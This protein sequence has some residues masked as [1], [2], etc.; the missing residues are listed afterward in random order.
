VAAKLNNK[1][2]NNYSSKCSPLSKEKET[3]L[4]NEGHVV[5]SKKKK[6]EY[7]NEI[8]AKNDQKTMTF[9]RNV[10]KDTG[11]KLK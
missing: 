3:M 4:I 2:A 1:I 11:I 5:R 10:S 6:I 8:F 9:T 7:M